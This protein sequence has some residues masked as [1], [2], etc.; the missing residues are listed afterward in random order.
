MAVAGLVVVGRPFAVW[1]GTLQVMPEGVLDAGFGRFFVGVRISNGSAQAWPAT[2]VRISARGR[3]ILAAAGVAVGDGW[4]NGDAAAVAQT[5]AT[6]WIP[7]PATVSGA[8]QLVFLKLDVSR[9]TVGLHTLELE[10]RDPTVPATTVKATA[11][12]PV[13]R[14]VCHGTQRTF[15]ASCD[16]GTLTASLSALTVDQ[17]SFRRVLGRARGIAGTAAPGTR[18][19]AET[20]RLRLRLRSLLCGDEG[21]VC[22]VLSDLNTSCALPSVLPPGPVPAS[23]TAAVAVLSDQATNLADRVKITD[24]TLFSNHAVVIG[25]DAVINGDVT[26]GGDVTIGDRSRVQGNVNAAGLIR[27]TQSG[28]AVITGA[29]NQHAPF[30]SM[31]IP[32][33][34]VTAGTTNVTVNSGQGTAANPFQIAPGSYGTVTVN[35]N[36]VIALAAGTYQ[37][38]QFVINAD[39]TVILNQ[40]ATPI[41]V[42]VQTNLSFGDRLIVKPGTTPPGVVAQFYSNQTTE[43][44]VGTD[45]LS[46]PMGL[47][48]PQGT[49]HVF[50]RTQLSGSLAGKTVTLEPDVGVGRVP[51]DDW[52]GTGTSG[53]EVL[54]YPTS[55]Q[56]GIAYNGTFF[57]TTGPQPFNLVSWNALLANAILQLD[58]GLQG[59]ITADFVATAEQAVVGNVKAAVLNAPTTAP[60]TT[61]PSTQAGSVD[62][63]VASVR[64]NRSLGSPL[65][66]FV[67]ASPEEAN[68]T[69][70]AVLG[71]AFTIGGQFLTNA[72]IDT[73]L[74]RAA[75]APNDLKVYKSGAGTGVT[76]GIIQ[77]LLP[78]V[79]RDDETGTLHF[80][81]QLLIVP[82]PTA[83]A[84]GDKMAGL[85]DSGALWIQTSTN[86]IVGLGHAVGSSGAIVSR[87][88][89]VVSAL[90]I[91][92][93]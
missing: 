36:N 75:T 6:E 51:V 71:G 31:T 33:K 12:L 43:V 5:A 8:I 64:G 73:V 4:S 81:N 46:F 87:F 10:L 37:M 47:T 24:G 82:D 52:L 9:A 56:Y 79:A 3:R 14:T 93:G 17:E 60:G 70:V 35:S 25:N 74:S 59:A 39:V 48:A 32:T 72:E 92:V 27:T 44:R 77:A 1:P 49:I 13:A 15:T 19:P 34:T 2:E 23:G 78:V 61:P 90:Q 42:R 38:A 63:A 88:Q 67:D 28:G 57:G 83:R 68:A 91:Q 80:I 16:E 69:P 86:K 40:T 29:R 85:G 55:L 50:S 7:V 26:S 45:I 18:T 30:V 66:S 65:Y 58:L 11:P 21:D 20:E 76:R 84:A 53:L 22:A 41:D 54:A 62:A 89:D